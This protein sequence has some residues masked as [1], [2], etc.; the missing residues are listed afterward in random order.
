MIK[1]PNLRAVL[2]AAVMILAGLGYLV[3]Q[4]VALMAD[5]N[6][7]GTFSASQ[8]VLWPASALAIM[9]GLGLL[10][11][12]ATHEFGRR[13][14]ILLGI[15]VALPS[16][17]P[18]DRY[19]ARR[20]R[21]NGTRTHRARN[22]LNQVRM[23]FA[24]GD[25]HFG[26]IDLVGG[27][28]D[29]RGDAPTRLE[30]GGELRAVAGGVND[31]VD[32]VRVLGS[33]SGVQVGGVV[34]G[35]VGTEAGRVVGVLGPGGGKDRGAAFLGELHG[36]RAD[37]TGGPGD[38]HD[39]AWLGVDGVNRG[40]RGGTG[41][42][43]C[44]RA[45]NRKSVGDLGREHCRRS[46]QLGEGAEAA[47]RHLHEHPEHR[48][49]HLEPG[50]AGANGFD[51]AAVIASQHDRKLVLHPAFD[52]AAGDGEVHAVHRAGLHAYEH[53]PRTRCG[54]GQVVHGGV[55]GEVVDRD[56]LHNGLLVF[57]GCRGSR[58]RIV[59]SVTITYTTIYQWAKSPVRWTQWPKSFRPPAR[60]SRFP[61]RTSSQ[62]PSA[63]RSPSSGCSRAVLTTR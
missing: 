45:F 51:R 15:T 59:T 40:E 1:T 41:E 31:R 25:L 57:P 34:D 33:Y 42:G 14:Q 5:P 35:L 58:P 6:P 13:P 26:A 29:R 17:R 55:G 4:Y 19:R 32:A 50:H 18:N 39:L 62:K 30:Q 7:R 49:A 43:E 12:A 3:A 16:G 46:D 21:V 60:R 53:L 11:V 10:V 52:H 24:G 37:T 36:E 61:T 63:S 20:G 22:L 27:E 2:A 56:G 9:V 47:E 44:G 28:T 38:Q 54:V 8:A 48:V 23:D